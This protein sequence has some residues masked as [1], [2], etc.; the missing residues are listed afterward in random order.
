MGGLLSNFTSK[1]RSSPSVISVVVTNVTELS[2]FSTIVGFFAIDQSDGLLL[3]SDVVTSILIKVPSELYGNYFSYPILEYMSKVANNESPQQIDAILATNWIVA[4]AIGS[5]LIVFIVVIAA[6]KIYQK[7]QSYIVSPAEKFT[8]ASNDNTD[9]E[10]VT[11]IMGERSVN[12]DVGSDD[13]IFGSMGDNAPEE[14]STTAFRE[15][16]LIDSSSVNSHQIPISITTKKHRVRGHG[17]IVAPIGVFDSPTASYETNPAQAWS[18]PTDE[19]ILELESKIIHVKPLQN[20]ERVDISQVIAPPEGK[21]EADSHCDKA[22]HHSRINPVSIPSNHDQTE[23]FSRAPIAWVI[24]EFPA[25]EAT[26]DT[27]FA[28]RN[29]LIET[30]SSDMEIPSVLTARL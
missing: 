8:D 6:I 2:D 10:I 4:I 25:R 23:Y 29:N 28:A 9:W 11:S 22:R 19:V 3:I 30:D 12:R 1:R 15:I 20:L 26:L 16:R 24:S 5:L 13:I 17:N 18:D 27:L 14:H 21:I 7:S